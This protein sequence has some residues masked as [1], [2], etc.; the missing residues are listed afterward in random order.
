M[1]S[2]THS[3]GRSKGKKN[4]SSGKHGGCILYGPNTHDTNNCKTLGDQAE[5]TKQ[6]Y[7][8]QDKTQDQQKKHVKSTTTYNH[9]GK[10]ADMNATVHQER[11]AAIASFV[12]KAKAA[13]KRKAE[14]KMN[15]NDKDLDDMSLT[16]YVISAIYGM[17]DIPDD[18]WN[19]SLESNKYGAGLAKIICIDTYRIN[20]IMNRRIIR[21]TKYVVGNYSQ[22]QTKYSNEWFNIIENEIHSKKKK[23]TQYTPVLYYCVTR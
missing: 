1:S 12:K 23:T 4:Q 11:K 14:A 10:K 2:T 19:I 13:K 8:S 7:A 16:G 3:E 22:T 17:K 9:G 5:C 20:K 21:D 18:G 15:H 6:T